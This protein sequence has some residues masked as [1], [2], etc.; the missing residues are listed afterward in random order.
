MIEIAKHQLSRV[1]P[2]AERIYYKALTQAYADASAKLLTANIT[3]QKRLIKVV[4]EIQAELYGLNEQFIY[5]LPDEIAEI[6]RIDNAYVVQ[7][8]TVPVKLANTGAVLYSLP[9]E[10]LKEVASLGSMTFFSTNAKGVTKQTTVTAEAML[11]SIAGKASEDVRSVIM[12]EYAQGTPIESIV[13]KIRPYLTTKQKAHARTVTRTL[14]NEASTKAANKYYD[15][16]D[17]YI[18][19]YIYVATLDGRTSR[20]CRSLDGRRFPTRKVW[21]NPPLHPNCRSSLDAVSKGYE[22]GERTVV[23]PDG[24]M[25]RVPRGFTYADALKRYPQLGNKKPLIFE[26]YEKSMKAV[27]LI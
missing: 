1:V 13:R 21:Y 16:N 23:L 7:E 27:T 10:T 11:K 12:A 8:L 24:T 3:T 9:K 17:E 14:L 5:A 25:D 2:D 6:I 19:G 15:L 20:I 18:D 4:K 26:Q 22:I